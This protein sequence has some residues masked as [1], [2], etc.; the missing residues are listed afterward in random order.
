[1][2]FTKLDLKSYVY[3]HRRLDT[4]E[5]FYVGIGNK[6]NFKRAF[7]KHNRNLHWERIVKKVGY[8]GDVIYKDISWEQACKYEINLI[9]MYGRKDLKL[10]TLV[11]LTNGGEGTLGRKC[12][13]E[14]K[15]KIG[16]KNRNKIKSI[17][18]RQKLSLSTKGKIVSEET[19]IKMSL[20]GKGKKMSKES[21]EKRRLSVNYVILNTETGIFY[22]GVKEAAFSL[23]VKPRT[24]N[25]WLSGQ[26]KNKSNLI[27]C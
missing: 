11:N 22:S 15:L 23:E 16:N 9:A 8:V 19:R 14:T 24:L 17:E 27:F 21:V 7:T 13:E 2:K 26:N 25:A 20:S 10:G 1:M 18:A 4:N 12:S 5:V 6:I 3:L